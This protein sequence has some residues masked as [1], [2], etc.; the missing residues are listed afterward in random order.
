MADEI[1]RNRGQFLGFGHHFFIGHE[2]RV[3]LDRDGFLGAFD[4]FRNLA[5][6]SHKRFARNL[7]V[8][9]VGGD[10]IDVERFEGSFDFAGDGAIQK[11]LH[12]NSLLVIGN[13][14]LVSRN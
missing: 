6:H 12:G 1:R 7:H 5:D 4:Q 8:A 10:A 14:R 13:L 2:M 9:W 3:D 11:E